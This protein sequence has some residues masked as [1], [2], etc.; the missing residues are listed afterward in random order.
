MEDTFLNDT[1]RAFFHGPNDPHWNLDSY[2]SVATVGSVGD[3]WKLHNTIAST[4]SDGMYFVMREHVFPCWDD[5]YNIN[6]GNISMKV[7]HEDT[8]DVVI[9]LVRSMLGETLIKPEYADRWADINGLSV[10][11]KKA[12]N[13]VKLWLATD[14]LAG[15]DAFHL[16]RRY[17]SSAMFTKFRDHIEAVKAVKQ[18]GP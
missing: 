11:P 7:A 9:E 3:Y 18:H 5:P 1:W 10:S 8:T 17:A 14:D 13:I 12:F 4:L 16:P 15:K 2:V 6:G